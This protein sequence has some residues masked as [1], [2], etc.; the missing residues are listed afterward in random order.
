MTQERRADAAP[1]RR[2]TDRPPARGRGLDHEIVLDAAL[3][4]VDDAGLPA[5]TMRRLGA[6]LGV[7]AMSIYTYFPNKAA[8]VDAMVEREARRLQ[9]VLPPPGDDAVDALVH[10]GLHVR[11]VLLDHP[12]LAATVVARQF[13]NDVWEERVGLGIALLR[14]IGVADEDAAVAAD[15]LATFGLGFIIY[16][17]GELAYRSELGEEAAV[18][19]AAMVERMAELDPDGPEAAAYHRRIAH[20]DGEDTMA[21]TYERGLRALLHGLRST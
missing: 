10:L 12:K 5:L 8:L 7:E 9:D 16:E 15:A 2:I 1:R 3:R 17:A 18:L 13:P 11:S 20:L 14:S 4:L 19:R 21:V 6:E